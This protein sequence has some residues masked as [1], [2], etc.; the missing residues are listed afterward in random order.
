M[1][2]MPPN[3]AL[4]TNPADAEPEVAVVGPRTRDRDDHRGHS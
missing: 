2:I 4:S 1:D 3:L